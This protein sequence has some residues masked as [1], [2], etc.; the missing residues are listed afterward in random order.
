MS[1]KHTYE[2]HSVNTLAH[3]VKGLAS[4]NTIAKWLAEKKIKPEM[5]DKSA[6]PFLF[7]RKH[8]DDVAEVLT[9]AH[10]ERV[11]RLT[12]NALEFKHVRETTRRNALAILRENQMRELGNRPRSHR[13][14]KDLATNDC[15]A[16][17]G[18]RLCAD[19]S[20]VRRIGNCNILGKPMKEKQK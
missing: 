5:T 7:T 4:R 18:V 1:S 3:R 17:G 10:D 16:V 6:A 15:D 19:V 13:G 9:R 11:G 2:K 20:E 14:E 8:L 12:T